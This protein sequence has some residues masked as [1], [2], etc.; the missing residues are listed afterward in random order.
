ML[1]EPSHPDDDRY[2]TRREVA[3]FLRCSVP[4]LERWA[5]NGDGPAFR[6]IA[7]KALYPLI[8]VR[9][10]ARGEPGRAG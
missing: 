2:L 3:A 8:A 9:R 7:K 4:T 6:I 1:D 10:Y 5:A